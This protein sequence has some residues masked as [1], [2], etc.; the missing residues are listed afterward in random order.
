MAHPVRRSRSAA[1]RSS[2]LVI[3]SATADYPPSATR[4]SSSGPHQTRRGCHQPM[5]CRPTGHPPYLPLLQITRCHHPAVSQHSMLSAPAAL[6][7]Q[8]ARSSGGAEECP[9][10]PFLTPS[11]PSRQQ[12]RQAGLGRC[13]TRQIQRARDGASGGGRRAARLQLF[14]GHL[15]HRHGEDPGRGRWSGGGCAVTTRVARRQHAAATIH[16]EW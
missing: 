4:A 2:P 5:H 3:R 12:H 1:G 13:A 7:H 15:R 16:G 10:Q 11:H 8:G 6:T 9:R 14:A